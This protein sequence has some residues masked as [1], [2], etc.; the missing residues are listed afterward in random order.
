MLRQ[1]EERTGRPIADL[2]DLICGTSTGGI[3]ATA[4]AL[5]RLTL[6][7][8]EDIY[9]QVPL[10]VQRTGMHL[11]VGVSVSSVPATVLALK[12]LTLRD[13][14]DSYRQDVIL[15]LLSQAAGSAA[16]NPLCVE[17]IYT[18]CNTATGRRSCVAPRRLKLGQL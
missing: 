3:L 5:K 15:P 4:L 6:S 14:E 7:D 11:I 2:F 12:C 1:L 10:T 17:L 18:S 9:R 16:E 8:C 13:C